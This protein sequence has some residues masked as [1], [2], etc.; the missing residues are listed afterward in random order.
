MNTNKNEIKCPICDCS[1]VV[2]FAKTKDYQN[3]DDKRDYYSYKC[4]S[5]NILFQ[6]PFPKKEDFDIIY[7]D[8]YYAHVENEKIPFSMKIL[9]FLFKHPLIANIVKPFVVK[10]YPYFDIIKDSK[11]I[12]DIGCGKGT[13]LNMLRKHN[14]ETYGIE[15][16][17]N[18][19]KI[20]EKNGHI[21]IEGDILS[22]NFNDNFFD[23]I[24]LFQ[25][26]EHIETP[27]AFLQ[28]TSRILKPG[29]YL[30]IGTPNIDSNLAIKYKNYWRSLEL[31]RHVI[32]H[33]PMSLYNLLDKLKFK[34][35]IYIRVS[36]WDI[37]S[38]SILNKSSDLSTKSN[39]I[40]ISFKF[41][42]F[43]NILF[44]LLFKNNSGSLLT[45]ISQ[46]Q[47]ENL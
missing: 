13:F 8:N 11:K 21:A 46:K 25:V 23:V 38:S 10:I 43:L 2:L 42:L 39:I 47:K 41:C 12:L 28:E 16:D 4:T 29:G 6:Y 18:A 45:T 31:P 37:K 20:L 32:L 27:S 24:T 5:C 7:K 9:D 17:I 15:P 1:N 19:N 36:P 44:N 30:I 35:K 40:K 3:L 26:F 22:S 34:T 14:K 33:S